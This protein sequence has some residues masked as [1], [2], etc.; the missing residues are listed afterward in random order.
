MVTHLGDNMCDTKEKIVSTRVSFEQFHMT[1][2]VTHD[3][4]NRLEEQK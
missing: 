2:I 1:G 4:D 3:S